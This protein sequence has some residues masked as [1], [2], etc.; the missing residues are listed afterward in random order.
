MAA[1]AA[2][3]RVCKW[4]ALCY[5]LAIWLPRRAEGVLAFLSMPV[6]PLCGVA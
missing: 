4:A 2:S 5:L 6:K 3:C 1:A